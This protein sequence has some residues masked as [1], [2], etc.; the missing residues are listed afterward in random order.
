MKSSA[1]ELLKKHPNLVH[2]ENLSV[3]THTQRQQGDWYINTLMLKG[4][5]VPFKYK[6]P[7]KF[8]SLKDQHINVTYYPENEVVAGIRLEVMQVIR[9]RRS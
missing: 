7:K 9:L 1:D 3:I 2:S 8:K 5:D 4:Y 6:R